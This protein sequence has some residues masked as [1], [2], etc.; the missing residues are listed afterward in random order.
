MSFSIFIVGYSRDV[1]PYLTQKLEFPLKDGKPLKKATIAKKVKKTPFLS[2]LF[3][4]EISI[5]QKENK[6]KKWLMGSFPF[7]AY[8]PKP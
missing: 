2:G 1:N 8:Q 5:E 6:I 3:I 4:I 7:P